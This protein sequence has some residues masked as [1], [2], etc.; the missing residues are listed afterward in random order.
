MDHLPQMVSSVRVCPH[1]KI[2]KKLQHNK[3]KKATQLPVSVLG[4]SNTEKL[5]ND[6]KENY[7]S[8]IIIDETTDVSTS[9]C[10]A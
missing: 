1:S 5:K 8:L 4:P 9:K 10:L 6:L 7:F 2:A 3:R